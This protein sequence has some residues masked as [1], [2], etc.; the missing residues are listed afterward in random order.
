MGDNDV[1]LHATAV[2][3]L[4]GGTRPI[5]PATLWRG[6]K[7]GRYPRP[8]KISPNANCWKRSEVVAAIETCAAL[9]EIVAA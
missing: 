3:R 6:V 9:R 4:I 8:L 2:C 1:L 7:A 5:N